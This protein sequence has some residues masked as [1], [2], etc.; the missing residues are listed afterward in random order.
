MGMLAT[1]APSSL[2]HADF[3]TPGFEKW[4]SVL[5]SD[6]LVRYDLVILGGGCAGLSLAIRLAAL[7]NQCPRTLVIEKR[8]TYSNDRTWCFWGE[9]SGPVKHLVQHKWKRI[10]L[11][12]GDRI[13]EV[14]CSTMPYQMISAEAFYGEALRVIT[15]SERIDLVM[16]VTMSALPLKNDGEWQ[17]ATDQ[18]QFSG[19]KV[20]D[21]RPVPLPNAGAAVLWQSFYGC[22]IEADCD[23]FDAGCAELM[24][25]TPGPQDRVNLNYVLP[26]SSRRALVEATVFGVDPLGREQLEDALKDALNRQT[27]GAGY[28]MLRTESGILPMG[29]ARPGQA[30][31]ATYIKAGLSAGA[32]R[33]STGY[34]FQRIQRWADQCAAGLGGGGLPLDHPADPSLL[35]ALDYLFVSVLRSCPQ[36]APSLFMGLFERTKTSRM[37]RFL[38]DAGTLSDYVAVAAALPA[39]LFIREIPRALRR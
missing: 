38:S 12:D 7:G 5:S 15:E 25:F 26:L 23:I 35:R 36:T 9:S 30:S 4:S 28:K 8:E 11:R 39:W 10:T 34:A 14:D 18:G 17:I 6:R 13:V 19:A 3:E 31:A 32:G 21:T 37:I 20:V 24:G 22:E 1:L 33:A 2:L 29:G 27:R 16:G